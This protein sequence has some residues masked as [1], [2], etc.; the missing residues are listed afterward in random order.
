MAIGEGRHYRFAKGYGDAA[1]NG[2]G[3]FYGHLLAEN[4]AKGQ[5]EAVVCAEHAQSRIGFNG[6]AQNFV[7]GEMLGNDFRTGIQ[8]KQVAEAVQKGG[9]YPKR[10]STSSGSS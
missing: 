5:L 3:G 6:R 10:A 8:I 1:C 4:G 2:R 7:P 9:Q